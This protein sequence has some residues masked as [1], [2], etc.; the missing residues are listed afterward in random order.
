MRVCYVCCN[1][2]LVWGFPAGAVGVSP[3]GNAGLQ[4]S[5]GMGKYVFNGGGGRGFVN[6]KEGCVPVPRRARYYSREL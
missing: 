4:G 6:E 3:R 5:D 1:I 2:Y